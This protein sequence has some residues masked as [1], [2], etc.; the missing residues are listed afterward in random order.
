MSEDDSLVK[1]QARVGSVLKDKWRLDTLIGVGG[2]AAVYAATHRNKNRVAVKML[3]AQ[4]SGDENVRTRFLREGYLA[5]TVEHTGAVKVLDDEVDEDG[6]AFLVMELL[7]GETIEARWARKKHRLDPGEVL[8][9]G[10]KLLDVLA[11]AHSKGLVHRDIKPENIFLTREGTLKVLDFGIARIF[12]GCATR[13]GRARA[14]SWERPLSWRPSRPSHTG[15]R[16]TV[17]PTSGLRA[18]RC[19]R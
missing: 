10:D 8:A 14:T 6:S 18:R 2:M 13:R 17:E 12:E 19:S 1:A 11:A 16:S 7:D 15:T 3:H 4:F 9:I 5:N